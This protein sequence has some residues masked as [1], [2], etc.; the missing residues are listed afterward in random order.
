M[1]DRFSWPILAALTVFC[2]AGCKILPTPTEE[3][4]AAAA[5]TFNPD[6]MV[7]DIWAS[8]VIPYLNEKAGHFAEV[9]ALAKSDAKAAGDK[10]GNPKKQANSPWTYAARAEGKIVASNT[11]SRAGSIDVDVDGDGKADLRAQIGPALRGT[12]LRD[13]LDFVN[14]NE[15]TNQIDFAQY[16]KAF[17]TYSDKTV[18]SKLPREALDGRT[19][20]LLG[21]YVPASGNDLPLLTPTE[22][23]I[24]PAP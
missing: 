6:K 9:N 2:L 12:A 15:F 24:G 14:F 8:K 4:R 18:L 16:G 3:D 13:V 17:N 23:E 20:K 5:N 11:Q 1:F 19:A 7:E 21:A 22:A 10:Y